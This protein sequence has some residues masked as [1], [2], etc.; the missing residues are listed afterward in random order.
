MVKD[1]QSPVKKLIQTNEEI[2][3]SRQQNDH[4]E[5][6]SSK[7]EKRVEENDPTDLA[8][9]IMTDVVSFFRHV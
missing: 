2:V 1:S 7:G 5:E 8:D 9:E 3:K 6:Q 4:S